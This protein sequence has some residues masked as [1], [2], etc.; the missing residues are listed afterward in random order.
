MWIEQGFP[1]GGNFPT[2]GR[3]VWGGGGGGEW[4]HL[5]KFVFSQSIV[6]IFTLHTSMYYVLF[7]YIYVYW[8]IFDRLF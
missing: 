3:S 5:K 2:E 7:I 8:P 4:E 1:S 6:K